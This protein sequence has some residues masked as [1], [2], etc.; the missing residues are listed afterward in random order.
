MSVQTRSTSF[1]ELP[2]PVPAGDGL[3]HGVRFARGGL[4]THADPF[5]GRTRLGDIVEC[6]R[7]VRMNLLDRGED[8]LRLGQP[9]TG[10]KGDATLVMRLDEMRPDLADLAESL[11][12]LVI[13]MQGKLRVAKPHLDR[14]RIGRLLDE[15][16]VGSLCL[17][18]FAAVE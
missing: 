16:L 11:C 14:C 5:E 17:R 7:I 4:G 18:Q 9:F 6:S 10:R 3:R 8:G 13:L 2:S 12:G 1:A 15:N